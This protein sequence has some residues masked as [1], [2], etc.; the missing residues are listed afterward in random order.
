VSMGRSAVGN[1]DGDR[2]GPPANHI[3]IVLERKPHFSPLLFLLFSSLLFL[4]YS[5]LLSLS[6]SLTGSVFRASSAP[7]SLLSLPPSFLSSSSRAI[8][9]NDVEILE[10]YRVVLALCCIVTHLNTESVRLNQ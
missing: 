5:P 7:Y 10:V 2:R 9:S 1:S 8:P 3:Q 4:L 6:L